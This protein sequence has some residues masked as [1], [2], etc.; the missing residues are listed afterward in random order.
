MSKAAKN[1]PKCGAE[2]GEGIR[3][4]WPA[5][6]RMKERLQA[7][8]LPW[9]PPKVP[10]LPPLAD[11]NAFEMHSRGMKQKEIA[12]QQH[13][14]QPTVS[15]G[16]SAVEFWLARTLPEDSG[17]LTG[18]ERFRV[19][20]VRHRI[21][22]E[23][24][25]SQAEQEYQR[26]CETLK[27]ERVRTKT[28]PEGRKHGGELITETVTD[29]YPKHQL[30]RVSYLRFIDKVEHE[31]AELHAGWLGNGNVNMTLDKAIDMEERD[32]WDRY[33]KWQQAKIDE[34]Q[35]KLAA[36]EAKGAEAKALG[37]GRRAPPPPA[38]EGLPSAGAGDLRSA[39][40]AG[41]ETR[42]E[43]VSAT[44]S[45]HE[46]EVAENRPDSGL[47]PPL[48]N[49]TTPAQETTC[50]E[51]EPSDLSRAQEVS[52]VN[53]TPATQ[54]KLGWVAKLATAIRQLGSAPAQLGATKL[55]AGL[56]TPPSPATAGLPDAG[57]GDL[58]S[59]VS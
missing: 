36:V 8:K 43:Q 53:K 24:L 52:N 37:A 10:G 30:G 51:T 59:A 29:V 48:V 17:N 39:V 11:R 47:R 5:G 1:R 42:A 4:V 57:A 13:R 54:P 35:A 14:S 3:G 23:H 18:W 33:V 27:I 9:T 41:S 26:S 32:R 22:L 20:M 25:K 16:I 34:L 19:A 49:A 55:G 7:P 50:V 12:A 40:S 56:L 58:R 31:L 15:R 45:E 44:C 28:Y 6:M 38:T 46:Y 2:L 21:Y